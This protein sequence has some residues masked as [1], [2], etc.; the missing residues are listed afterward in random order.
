MM[1][2]PRYAAVAP[3]ATA[4]VATS[5]GVTARL[6]PIV[7]PRWARRCGVL[8]AKY[9]DAAYASSMRWP[10]RRRSTHRSS[11]GR[12]RSEA[13]SGAARAACTTRNDRC[14]HND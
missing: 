8:S 14:K 12:S 2:E 13:V 5:V 3:A 11:A 10:V 7:T 1:N 6:T 4:L 9:R